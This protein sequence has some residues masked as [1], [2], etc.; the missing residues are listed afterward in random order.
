MGTCC[1]SD[2]SKPKVH[3]LEE[4]I[5]ARENRLGFYNC[6]PARIIAQIRTKVAD[7]KLSLSEF[8]SIGKH[9]SFSV[10][11]IGDPSTQMGAF[12]KLFQSKG[13][14]TALDMEKVIALIVLAE[15]PPKG[16]EENLYFLRQL[17]DPHVEHVISR[18]T[19]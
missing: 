6:E 2:A 12:Y 8:E 3:K 14:E 1:A 10:D 15:K 5:V 11:D 7:G 4:E 19:F 13:D 17:C 18:K 9:F 16:M